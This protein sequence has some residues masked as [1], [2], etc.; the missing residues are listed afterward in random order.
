[1]LLQNTLVLTSGEFVVVLASSIGHA[2]I[3]MQDDPHS[4]MTPHEVQ[5]GLESDVKQPRLSNLFA[6]LAPS[7]RLQVESQRS[8]RLS[9]EAALG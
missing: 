9:K 6:L 3:A 7:L 8:F 4:G 2:P 5:L 1:M